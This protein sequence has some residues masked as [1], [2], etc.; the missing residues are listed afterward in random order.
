MKGTPVVD[1]D[2]DMIA[3]KLA[4]ADDFDAALLVAA[5]M[6]AYEREVQRIRRKE[7]RR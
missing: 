5:I 6:D 3:G 7:T 4:S 1:I 2:P